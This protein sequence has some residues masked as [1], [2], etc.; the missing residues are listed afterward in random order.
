M[1]QETKVGLL[2]GLALILLVG[3][4]LSDL[5]TT[6]SP[7]SAEASS[8]AATEFGR[9]AQAGIYD[10]QEQSPIRPAI[11][12]SEFDRMPG[13]A[14]EPAQDYHTPS[15]NPPV[16]SWSPPKPST[17][18][19]ASPSLPGLTHEP[20][21]PDLDTLEANNDAVAQFQR[22]FEA[23]RLAVQNPDQ[24]ES[25]PTAFNQELSRMSQLPAQI[26]PIPAVPSAVAGGTTYI[27]YVQAGQTLAEIARQ[28]YGNPEFAAAIA[29]TNPTK[30]DREGQVRAGARLEIP[31]LGS[32]VFSRLFQPVHEEHAIKVDGVI[33]ALPDRPAGP[34]VEV[35]SSN[36]KEIE[37]QPGDTLSE[38]ASEHLGT[39]KRWRELIEA[40]RDQLETAAD[41][42]SGMTL[43][44]PE[45]SASVAAT[46]TKTDTP[47]RAVTPTVSQKK[48]TP[49]TT[50][51]V[52]AG[53]NLTRIAARELGDGE[54]WDDLLEANR[55]QLESPELL[56]VGMV[57]KL[58][59][60]SVRPAE[61]AK[62]TA[63]SEIRKPKAETPK[64]YTVQSGDNLTRIAARELG[65]G[66]RWRE[67]FE[68]NADQLDSPND[69]FAGQTLR[70]P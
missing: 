60:A 14:A 38:L 35:A 29:Q 30:V 58:P 66:D 41:L 10:A 49:R 46:Q 32:P 26:E 70:L 53:D 6:G 44:L 4:V 19:P 21:L 9:E 67:L 11:R 7:E 27:H 20:P 62:P 47:S 15:T 43:R 37:V 36:V 57:L 31:P 69:L 18:G 3:L 24:P 65:D 52:Q 39:S 2:I 33:P 51:T 42:R 59:T 50:Y 56:Q 8:N 64:T 17:P 28:H 34:T 5:F 12:Q 40:N 55:D 48:A 61:S 23:M 25:D 54:R 68:A 45:G 13:F 16:E 63:T 1:A 22:S